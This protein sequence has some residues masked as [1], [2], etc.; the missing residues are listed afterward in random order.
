MPA[1]PATRP[2]QILVAPPE[3]RASPA[4]PAP[5][6]RLDVRVASSA[7]R[8]P[9]QNRRGD[10]LGRWVVAAIVL[11]VGVIFATSYFH[12]EPGVDGPPAA[13]PNQRHRSIDSRRSGMGWLSERSRRRAPPMGW[14]SMARS[15]TWPMRPPSP[16][17]AGGAAGF[18]GK[19]GPDPKSSIR[20]N[21]ARAGRGRAF[22]NAVR[23]PARCGDRGRGNV[24]LVVTEQ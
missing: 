13:Q 3:E 17:P 10:N 2:I 9:R 20:R 23:Q 18:S 24:C 4:A 11:V 22:R 16:A 8:A 1:S 19:R 7:A 12:H 5:T 14:S 21:H 15:P 6:A